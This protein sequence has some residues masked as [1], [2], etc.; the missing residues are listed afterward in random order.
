MCVC[1]CVCNYIYICMYIC[2]SVFIDYNHSG[3][4]N[5]TG[6]EMTKIQIS[7]KVG[8]VIQISRKQITKS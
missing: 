4:Q 8:I 5:H 6:N 1:V 2:T 3:S 7:R